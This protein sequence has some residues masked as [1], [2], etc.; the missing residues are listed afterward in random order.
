MEVLSRDV[1]RHLRKRGIRQATDPQRLAM[2]PILEGKDVLLIAP[3]GYGKTEATFGPLL[4]RLVEE[5]SEAIGLIYIAPLRALNRDILERMSNWCEDLD[6]TIS[7]RH[8]DTERSERT[9]QARKPPDVLVTTPETL[10]I[11]FTGSRLREGLKNVRSIIVDEVHELYGEER[12]AQLEL[13]LARLDHLAGRKVQR[14]GL[15]ATVWSAKDVAS[16]LGGPT[17]K[18]EI[19]RG[20]WKKRFSFE[21]DSPEVMPED[22]ETSKAI[23]C[24]PKVASV[25]RR[26]TELSAMS[27]SVLLFAN[28]RDMAEALSA[29]L[30]LFDPALKLGVHHGSLS[31]EA[32]METEREF[33]E[34]KLK[35]LV[36]TSSMEL[37][38]D[39]G[40]VDLVI[41]FKSPKEVSRL[42]QRAGRAGHRVEEVSR[43][44]VLAT[45]SDDVLESAVIAHLA[46]KGRLERRGSRKMML[47]VLANQALSMASSEKSYHLSDLLAMARSTHTFQDLTEEGLMRVIRFLNDSMVLYFDEGTGD[48][49]GGRRAREY[50][51]DNISMLPEERVMEIKDLSTRKVIG[52]LDMDFVLSNLEPY[53]RFIVRG[54]PWRVVDITDDEV[55]VEPVSDLGPV[56]AWSGSDIPVPWEVAREVARVRKELVRWLKEESGRP[57]VFRDLPMTS[58]AKRTVISSFKEQLE[59]GF[60][61]PDTDT[62]TLEIGQEGAIMGVCGGT[63]VNETLGRV[64][65]SLISAKHGGV[66]VVDKDPYRVMMMG[67]LRLKA[68]DL[69]WALDNAP[70]NELDRMVPILLRNS[71]LLRWQ[72]MHVARKFGV[73]GKVEDPKRF[74]LKRLLARFRDT[75][76]MEDAMAR[77]M[78]E[79]L[80]MENTSRV[81]S[82]IRDG[83][84][85]LIVQKISP[86]SMEGSLARSEFMTPETA[87]SEVLTA[88]KERLMTSAVKL[89]CMSCGSSMRAT[90]ERAR[91][92]TGCHRCGSRMLAPL[93]PGDMRTIGAVEEG[94]V[95]KKKLTGD[96]KKRLEAAVMAAHLF[97]QYGY[98]AVLCMAGRGVGPKTA[99]RI[100]SMNYEDDDDLV[101]R[102]FGEEIRYARTRRFW[103]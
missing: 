96:D 33:K 86:L 43:C 68:A 27:G 49:K 77:V 40:K 45:G 84:V 90:A 41:Q 50:F 32:R 42:L 75:M 23:G 89:T 103:D 91:T 95:K 54:Q 93:P 72:M 55:V 28:S 1:T 52:T 58:E 80:D 67:D 30:R 38:M 10:Q 26:I 22:K 4:Q 47:G 19:I 87:R 18:V 63:K 100:L 102:V 44:V 9:R 12:G 39:I 24:S 17:R 71:P 56:P 13:A 36:C 64:L 57:G 94:L 2:G 79:R 85:Q 61:T 92:I 51:Y 59:E 73:L 69:R 60:G 46:I 74:P 35:V 82:S 8:S 81:L 34:G 99:G 98:K 6:L 11:M 5:R 16:Y 29:R 76:I 14:I 83:K 25:I 7:V 53:S 65:S 101:R 70:V 66:I 37:G 62:I 31:R 21:V 20:D 3:T 88:V 48:I 15:S 78:E 97:Q